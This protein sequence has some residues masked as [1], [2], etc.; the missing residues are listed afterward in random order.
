MPLF[1]RHNRLEANCPICS[2]EAAG[3]KRA[4][5]ARSG[6]PRRTGSTAA[7][8]STRRGG[9]GGNRLVTK[10]LQRA[11]EDGYSHPLIP[12]VRASADAERLAQALALA[13]DRLEPPGPYP[14]LAQLDD[15][16]EAHW[17]AFLLALAGPEN[18]Q[19]QAA[20]CA[21]R[22]AWADGGV[23]GLGPDKASTLTAYRA[24]V[25][26]H[27][28]TQAAA[29]AGVAS[30]TPAKRFARTFDRLALPGFGR[31]ERFELLL[32]LAAAGLQALEADAL[33][34]AV[35]HDD[36]TTLAAKRALS[37]GDALLLERRAAEL[38]AGVGVPLGALDRALALWDRPGPLAHPGAQRLAAVRAALHVE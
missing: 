21:A 16:E 4:Q 2:R 15:P 3:A 35:A 6:P 29:L 36:A 25:D 9:S 14:A 1:C 12:G 22:P 26:R 17:L 32:N 7:R 37:S 38:A 31:A 20:L 34:V 10:R 13:A 30:S 5:P 23:D 28:A 11:T 18:A 33:H 24:W 27:G 8:P 19:L